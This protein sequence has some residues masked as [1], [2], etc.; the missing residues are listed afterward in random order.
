MGTE[1]PF[2]INQMYYISEQ[3]KLLYDSLDNEQKVQRFNTLINWVQ[4]NPVN[5]RWLKQFIASVLPRNFF[6]EK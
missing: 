2:K 5:W 4:H 1:V 6:F 3:Q